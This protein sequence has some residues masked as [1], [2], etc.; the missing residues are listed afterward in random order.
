MLPEHDFAT[1]DKSIPVDSYEA[2]VLQPSQG[3]PGLAP[4]ARKPLP[5]LYPGTYPPKT[6]FLEVFNKS[7]LQHPLQSPSFG[8]SFE[9]RD[10]LVSL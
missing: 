6:R 9:L 4:A 1:R 10:L 7:K 2:S 8:S 5:I 3:V